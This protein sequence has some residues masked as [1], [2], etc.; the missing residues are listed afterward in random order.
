MGLQALL[1]RDQTKPREILSLIK[2]DYSIYSLHYPAPART[3]SAIVAQ[4]MNKAA[5]R[6]RV[7]RESA[8]SLCVDIV[9]DNAY[10]RE[11]TSKFVPI[12]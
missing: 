12:R 11:Q 1:R 2:P 9:A 6:N 7:G 8:R 3:F 10:C 5:N 4:I